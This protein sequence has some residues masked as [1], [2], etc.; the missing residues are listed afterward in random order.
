[1]LHYCR[2]ACQ[3]NGMVCVNFHEPCVGLQY[4]QGWL[5]SGAS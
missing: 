2:A 1:M 3:H 4:H 5:Y